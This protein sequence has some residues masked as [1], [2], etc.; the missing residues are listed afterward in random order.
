MTQIAGLQTFTIGD[1]EVTVINDG[2][3]QFDAGLYGTNAPEG[4]VAEQLSAANLP[5]DYVPST[6][7]LMLIR[8]GDKTI[9][10]D[11]G[12][13][14][15]TMPDSPANTG[16]LLPTLATIGIQPSDVTDLILTHFH[17]DHIGGVSEDGTANFPN[18]QHYFPQAEQDFIGA[19]PQGTPL[20][21][22]IDLANA[23]L[24]PI[25]ANDQLALY[26][27]GQEVVSG[28]HA[29]AAPGHS[30]GH[31]ALVI[32]SNS[33]QLLHMVDIANHFL[34]LLQNPD[35]HFGFDAMP[36]VA[37]QTRKTLLNRAVDEKLPVIGYHFPFP[38]VGYISRAGDGYRYLPTIR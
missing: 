28:I 20:D 32:E 10:I 29:L 26:Q 3:A 6:A 23:K 15:F 2:I 12:W 35:Y 33:E 38:G 22:F 9:L 17:P 13:G 18:A 21:P 4:A 34:V 37:V 8:A 36:D 19:G 31:V 30:P 1:F 24:A 5:T 27:D 11:T 25:K 16:K 14:Q 7:N